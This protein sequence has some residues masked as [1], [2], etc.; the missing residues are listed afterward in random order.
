[1]LQENLLSC[2]NKNLIYLDLLLDLQFFSYQ[3]IYLL[4]INWRDAL[5]VFFYL[6]QIFIFLHYFINSFLLKYFIFKILKL[7]IYYFLFLL[8]Y[9]K[10]KNYFK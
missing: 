3:L 9:I 6:K 5:L 1:M 2:D 7:L 4:K 8:N 10:K